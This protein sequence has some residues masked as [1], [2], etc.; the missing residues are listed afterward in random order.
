M[1]RLRLAGGGI[2][3][4]LTLLGGCGWKRDP[5]LAPASGTVTNAGKPLAHVL[6]RF[7]PAER[8]IPP[9]WLSEATTDDTGRFVLV[10]SRGPG[11]VVGK[12]RVTVSE[13]AVPDEIRD[14]QARVSEWLR[15]L[16]GRPIPDRFGT[17]ATSP[18]EATVEEGGSSIDFDL[19]R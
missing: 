12:H 2:L 10:T 17:S 6:V 19:S 13:G 5:V 9:E 7:M 11:A 4:A 16:A 15:S 14:D 8:G 1:S 3:L 18:L